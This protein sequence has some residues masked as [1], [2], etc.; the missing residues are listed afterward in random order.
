V[1]SGLISYG[2]GLRSRSQILRY[3]LTAVLLAAAASAIGAWWASGELLPGWWRVPL[4]VAPT[5]VVAAW[6]LGRDTRSGVV[7]CAAG[8]LVACSLAVLLAWRPEPALF[9]A[10]RAQGRT[11]TATAQRTIATVPPGSCVAATG[12][13]I[14]PLAEL[15]PW[16]SACVYST[17]TFR[18]F[19]LTRP[20]NSHAM[21]LT[22]TTNGAASGGDGCAHRVVGNWWAHTSSDESNPVDPCPAGFRYEPGP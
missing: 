15:G 8:A 1:A 7:A 12:A 21:T 20:A 2:Y 5:A 14:G 11:A 10:L 3:R 19:V 18:E 22:W 9:P 6:C 13:E 4:V 16:A 17:G